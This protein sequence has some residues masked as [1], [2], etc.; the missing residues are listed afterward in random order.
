MKRGRGLPELVDVAVVAQPPHPD[1]TA[2]VV[3]TPEIERWRVVVKR[4]VMTGY[5]N[6][7]WDA[8]ME[9]EQ[10]IREIG[11]MEC[12]VLLDRTPPH[13]NDYETVADLRMAIEKRR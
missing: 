11:D 8:A 13:P 1:W 3:A 2:Q 12:T 9:M 5:I 4:T 6:L 7:P 10:Q